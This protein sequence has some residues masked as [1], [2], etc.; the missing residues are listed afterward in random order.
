[1]MSVATFSSSQSS[2]TGQDTST[3]RGPETLRRAVVTKDKL[4]FL[5]L[6]TEHMVTVPCRLDDPMK[7]F[8]SN[9]LPYLERSWTINTI[10]YQ[11]FVPSDTYAACRCR[12]LRCLN[13]TRSSVPL[14]LLGKRWYMRVDVLRDWR[15]LE[16]IVLRLRTLSQSAVNDLQRGRQVYSW[17]DPSHYGYGRGHVDHTKLTLM[18]I[19]SRAAFMLILA[20][21]A[22]NAA[23]RGNFW[24]EIAAPHFD[25]HIC[26][27]FRETWVA[28]QGEGFQPLQRIGVFVDVGNCDFTDAFATMISHGIPL[29]VYWGHLDKRNAGRYGEKRYEPT[30]REL[31]DALKRREELPEMVEDDGAR[32]AIGLRRVPLES[33]FIRSPSPVQNS[34]P[35][36]VGAWEADDFAQEQPPP[37]GVGAWGADNF[38]QE[39]AACHLGPKIQY[40]PLEKTEKPH[41]Q[42]L[43]ETWQDFFSR[44][45]ACNTKIME[46]ESEQAHQAHLQREEHGKK[47]RMPGSKGAAVF[48]WRVSDEKGYRVHRNVFRG[49]VEDVW[50]EYRDSQRQYDAFH[51][52]WDLNSDFDPTARFETEDEEEEEDY[53]GVGA[54]PEAMEP[55]ATV[56]HSHQ[57]VEKEGL[58]LRLV[59]QEESKLRPEKLGT[60]TLEKILTMVHGIFIPPSETD[61]AS[62]SAVET[63]KVER[64]KSS[65]SGKTAERDAYNAIPNKQLSVLYDGLLSRGNVPHRFPVEWSDLDPSSPQYLL[66]AYNK[67]FK[68]SKIR[69][70]EGMEAVYAISDDKE[71]DYELILPCARAV[72]LALRQASSHTLDELTEYLCTWGIRLL[73]CKRILV[74]D[75]QPRT[76]LRAVERIPY[77]MKGSK[78]DMEDYSSYVGRRRQLFKNNEILRAALKHGGLIWRLAIEEAPEDY[79]T[80]G[81]GSRVT[82][83]GGFLRTA[84]GDE[85]WD[86]MLTEDQIDVICGVY[87]VEREGDDRKKGFGA[88]RQLLAEHLSWFP[89]DASWKGSGLDYWYQRR[90]EKYLSGDFKCETQT[91]WKRSLKLWRDA[92]KVSGRLEHLFFTRC[93]CLATRI[94][95]YLLTLFGRISYEGNRVTRK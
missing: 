30:E 28:R 75:R 25:R 86:E 19:K 93:K 41:Q 14:E 23:R 80:T 1:M 29:W 84:E 36:G 5:L 58:G 70:A 95:S 66:N 88:H 55:S 44:R 69:M 82:Q 73:T 9:P 8:P 45:K 83:V 16:T 67:S 63:Q 37:L 11:P 61:G 35:W 53:F 46:S 62:M 18:I 89:K 40:E 56:P 24:D 78:L 94:P 77:R 13:Y 6:G 57:P 26:D 43:G 33:R 12:L 81:P 71:T 59:R 10:P 74:R 49:E 60:A 15:E 39:Q 54:A 3:S 4:L 2:L 65:L 79:V 92:P 90:V 72:L 7:C 50:M 22:C 27:L 91:E 21:I 34:P 17:P 38:V 20:E 48:T 42:R 51:N 85:L 68:I 47:S 31:W 52:E 32:L 64:C 87:K 76:F